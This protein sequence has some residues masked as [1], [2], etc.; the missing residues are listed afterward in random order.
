MIVADV[1]VDGALVL[2]EADEHRMF[3]ALEGGLGGQRLD[4]DLH[5]VGVT[6]AFRFLVVLKPQPIPERL[7]V[8]PV[9]LATTVDHD[10]GIAVPV[11]LRPR[12]VPGRFRRKLQCQEM[13]I[14]L[15]RSERF[16]L[17]TLRFEV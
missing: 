13:P 1:D 9:R 4:G 12:C 10:F 2:G 15:A 14:L 16:E 3:G 5:C 8:N 17:P 7:A 11:G 6:A